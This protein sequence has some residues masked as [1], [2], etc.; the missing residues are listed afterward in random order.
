[1]SLEKISFNGKQIG[2]GKAKTI[3]DLM[4]LGLYT[5]E[6]DD[7]EKMQYLEWFQKNKYEDKI[8]LKA[9]GKPLMVPI[10]QRGYLIMTLRLELIT[11]GF[12]RS[13]RRYDEKYGDLNR[14]NPVKNVKFDNSD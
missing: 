11:N 14:S 12:L 6:L 5:P 10:N 13:I 2:L 4:R 1:M 8:N 9:R 3:Y 7:K